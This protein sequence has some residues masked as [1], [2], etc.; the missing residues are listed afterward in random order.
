MIP[1]KFRQIVARQ[2]QESS[3]RSKSI[4][5]KVNKST[6]Q[7]DQAFVEQIIGALPTW[8]PKFLQHV[9]GLVIEPLIKT[10]KK[11]Q[12]MSIPSL[13]SL[14]FDQNSD[15]CTLVAHEFIRI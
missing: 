9:V 7:L 3:G 14:I 4:L 11:A 15:F 8:K 10:L 6:G 5:L 12:V 13:S 2:Y 1:W